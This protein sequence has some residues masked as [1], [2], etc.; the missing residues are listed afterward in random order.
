MLVGIGLLAFCHHGGVS[1]AWCASGDAFRTMTSIVAATRSAVRGDGIGD[2]REQRQS[3]CPVGLVGTGGRVGSAAA[4][5]VRRWRLA[6]LAR[7]RAGGERQP[8]E[9]ARGLRRAGDAR[10]RHPSPAR[11]QGERPARRSRRRCGDRARTR[12]A[13]SARRNDRRLQ[14]GDR[15]PGDRRGRT[16]AGRDLA[17]SGGSSRQL[18][19]PRVFHR[20]ARRRRA[21]SDRRRRARQG[22]PGG[23]VHRRGPPRRRRGRISAAPSWSACRRAISASSTASCSA[24]TPT[25]PRL[26]L[27]EDGTP[28]AG[29]PEPPPAEA[30]QR[31]EWLADV[32]A[33]RPQ[34]G[35]VRGV[36]V[37]RRHRARDRLSPADELSGLRH[38]RPPLELG[39]RRMARRPWRRTW[40][41][42][43]RQR[44][45]CSH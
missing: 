3:R 9:C 5:G 37:D 35:L 27:R 8:A 10:V 30:R 11:R 42:A 19:R 36:S 12:V 4:A 29:Y 13:R 38:H 31:D 20:P 28:L 43:F 6:G 17:L 26:L 2:E 32:I 40:S 14:P 41:S 23:R 39:G 24:A 18:Q 1:V 21:V 7:H 45:A 34:G 44:W 33:R 22:N 25:T 16:R 15:D